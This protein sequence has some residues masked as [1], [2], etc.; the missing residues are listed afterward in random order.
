MVI[1]YWDLFVSCTLVIGYFGRYMKKIL[2]IEDEQEASA[3][4]AS[5]L[6]RQGYQVTPVHTGQAALKILAEDDFDLAII[7]L[8]LPD[9]NGQELCT[10]IRRNQKT[11]HL[12]IIVSTALGDESTEELCQKLGANV[13]LAKPYGVEE[14]LNAVKK[15]LEKEIG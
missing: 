2:L 7:D 1:D 11:K 4:I 15:C 12:P 3:D 8:I 14:L 13:F 6:Q 10:L 9:L 5:F